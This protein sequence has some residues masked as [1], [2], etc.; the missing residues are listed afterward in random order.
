MDMRAE[1]QLTHGFVQLHPVEASRQLEAFEPQAAAAMLTPLPTVDIANVLGC[2]QPGFAARILEHISSNQAAA[3]VSI[4]P[5]STAFVV[6]RQLS[7]EFQTQVIEQLGPDHGPR[8]RR[9]LRQPKQTAGSLANPRVLTLPP[10]I[11]VTDAIHLLKGNPKQSSYYLYVVDRD[12]KLDGVVTMKQLLVADQHDF[13]GTVMNNQVVSIAA[14]LTNEELVGHPHW[15]QFP[16]L[17]VVDQGGV[18]LGVLRYRT[19]QQ[20]IEETATRASPGSLP[21]A[22]IQL[23]EAYSLA[24][25]RVLTELSQTA[26]DSSS[27]I[28]SSNIHEDQDR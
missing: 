15:Q 4:L 10:D 21:T 1:D 18:F 26:R 9:A 5:S 27:S 11:T 6:V 22:L 17:P 19:L 13:I 20:V 24:G 25:I 8:F 16:M 12:A 7:S 3:V 14:A 23:W 28:E 2:C